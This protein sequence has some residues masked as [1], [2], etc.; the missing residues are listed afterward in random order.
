M[1]KYKKLALKKFKIAKL[2]HTLNIKGG[3]LTNTNCGEI[4]GE[5]IG[6][7]SCLNDVCNN[8]TH[9]FDTCHTQGTINTRTSDSLGDYS[10]NIM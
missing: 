2:A 5:T 7:T 10:I 6:V 9:E 3:A 4:S 1:K 8:E